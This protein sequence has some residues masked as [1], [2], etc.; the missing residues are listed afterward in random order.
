[1][2]KIV[3]PGSLI[4]D[5]AG[6]AP[7]LPIGGE[8]V[9][10]ESF[11]VGPGGKG[12]N[13]M[14]AASRAGAETVIIGC[15]GKD[16]LAYVLTDHYK[17]EGMT[18][19]HIR[20]SDTASTGAALIEI[21]T[22]SGQN[23]IVIISGASGEVSDADVFEAEADFADCDAVLCQ[24]ETSIASVQAAIKL[25][26]KYGKPIILNPAPFVKV[27]ESIYDGIDYLTPNETE[28]EYITGI[29]IDSLADANRAAEKLLSMGVKKAV[30]TL[31]KRGSYFYDGKR[32]IIFPCLPLKAVD[33]TGAGDAFSGGFATAISEGMD[34]ETALKF[35]TCTSNISVTRKG[36][37]PAMPHRDEIAALMKTAYGIDI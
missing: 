19:R 31:G 23:R 26:K 15:I 5:L 18:T 7:H 9:M 2:G 1:M 22:A 28:A 4:V 32:E 21:D 8:T 29:R 25:G 10:G 11:A 13:Q 27:P 20:I 16:A 14:T 30:L 33:T 36:S 24:F 12:S 34:D 3:G 35:A 17:N 6:Y 37:S